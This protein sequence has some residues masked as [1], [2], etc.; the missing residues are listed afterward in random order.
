MLNKSFIHRGAPFTMCIYLVY[1]KNHRHNP[2][3]LKQD[4][5]NEKS[6]THFLPEI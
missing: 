1:K 2:D 6:R 5:T 4:E 3:T